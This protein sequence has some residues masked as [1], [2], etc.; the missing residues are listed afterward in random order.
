MVDDYIDWYSRNEKS[1]GVEPVIAFL[2]IGSN[3]KILFKHKQTKTT[4]K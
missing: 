4:R 2:S 1:L 3:R